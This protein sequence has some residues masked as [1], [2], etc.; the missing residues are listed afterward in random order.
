MVDKLKDVVAFKAAELESARSHLF[1]ETATLKMRL[2]SNAYPLH[3]IHLKFLKLQVSRLGCAYTIALKR[4]QC[5]VSA[6]TLIG[7]W[8]SFE[9]ISAL[10]AVEDLIV[11]FDDMRDTTKDFWCRHKSY[12]R[13]LLGLVRTTGQVH[14]QGFSK[15]R[16]LYDI[17]RNCLGGEV[18]KTADEWTARKNFVAT[19]LNLQVVNVPKQMFNCEAYHQ[20]LDIPTAGEHL[21]PQFFSMDFG[22]NSVSHIYPDEAGLFEI[23]MFVEVHGAISVDTGTSVSTCFE[24]TLLQAAS[25]PVRA[26]LDGVHD[27]QLAASLELT[28]SWWTCDP[29]TDDTDRAVPSP[30]DQVSATYHPVPQLLMSRMR[31]S[32]STRI[33]CGEYL[34]ASG[35]SPEEVRP[36]GVRE[37]H[38]LTDRV[39]DFVNNLQKH[40]PD[41]EECSQ[42]FNFLSDPHMTATTSPDRGLYFAPVRPEISVLNYVLPSTSFCVESQTS[43]GFNWMSTEWEVRREV[44][45]ASAHLEVSRKRTATRTV[46]CENGLKRSALHG[47]FELKRSP[48]TDGRGLHAH[49]QVNIFDSQCR[50]HKAYATLNSLV[51]RYCHLPLL[52]IAHTGSTPHRSVIS[53]DAPGLD[54]EWLHVQPWYN[55]SE[56]QRFV[57]NFGRLIADS[58]TSEW[59]LGMASRSYVAAF[60]SVDSGRT[61]YRSQSN[62]G[63]L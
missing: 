7:R 14:H 21:G 27:A 44:V 37:H 9:G 42:F 50:L 48:E 23:T 25:H 49:S 55:D 53:D 20:G 56:Q 2:E 13:S 22:S 36:E 38:G 47:A 32:I 16:E 30:A 60:R 33:F 19:S 52:D 59:V 12:V 17:A 45:A 54:R 3:S 31:S 6:V 39:A 46:P 10:P 4:Y 18:Q 62:P 40:H 8:C 26:R 35:L 11:G 41:R 63:E 58:F 1:V 34:L 28:R 15:L 61:V 5:A 43:E 24:S 51:V 29:P 57:P